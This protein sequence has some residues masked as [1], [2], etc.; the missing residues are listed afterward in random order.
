M[1]K[2]VFINPKYEYLRN[3]ILQIPAIMEQEGTYIYGGRRNL[4]KL[5]EAE[6][7]TQLNVKRFQK[8]RLLNNL[9]Y[10]SGIRKPKGV[11]A[12]TYPAI[13]LAKG[14]ETPEAVAYIEYRNAAGLLQHSYFISRQCPYR[15]LLYELGDAT[16]DV[17][18]PLAKALARYTAYM[19]DHEVLHLDYSPG[20]ILWD[21][22]ADGTY[23][24][25]SVDINRMRFG[26]VNMQ[27]G[28]KSFCRLWGPKAFIQLLVEE[29]AHAR[30]FDPA[31]CTAITMKARAEFWQRY[32]KKREIEFKLEL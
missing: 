8:P 10:S 14:I 15:H 4:I 25:S 21:I 23:H 7:G 22:D 9:I 16:P 12:F 18:D 17:Y 26:A 11:R 30:H 29:Y 24:F 20:N 13:L 28:C 27:E 5:F 19:H 6:D 2:K 31:T 32:Q 1:K 3:Y